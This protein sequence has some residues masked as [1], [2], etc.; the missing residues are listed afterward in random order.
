M[1][2]IESKDNIKYKI[3]LSLKTKK[4]REQNGL[5]LVEGLRNIKLALD[6]SY[7]SEYLF[8]NEKNID[9]EEIRGL[10]EKEEN[11]Y[12]ISEKLF[13]NLSETITSQG[14]IGIFKI[15]QT[16][17]RDVLNE[18]TILLL[19]R[20]QDPGNLGTII[21]TA[22]AAG[23]KTIL[24]TKGT[25]D[26]YSPKVVRAAMGS[27]FYMNILPIEDVNLLKENGYFIISSALENSCCYKDIEVNEK[28]VLVLGNEA[29]GISKEIL[30]ISDKK[31]KIPIFGKAESL[32]VAIAGAI[33]MYEYQT[34]SLK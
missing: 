20:I 5:F 2:K 1:N 23:I 11:S 10:L 14:I 4:G 8:L 27:I 25:T 29:N 34:K 22:D 18:N 31:V 15:S 6:Y 13:E 3:A 17:A 16:E 21:R 30:N 7:K 32:N 33:L 9:N 28:L 24:Y 19:D 12:I 26:P